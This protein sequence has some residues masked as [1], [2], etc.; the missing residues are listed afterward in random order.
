MSD[1]VH[2]HRWQ[3]T[4]LP[5]PWDSLGK[6]AGVGCHFLL[7]LTDQL[8]DFLTATHHLRPPYLASSEKGLCTYLE[9]TRPQGLHTQ[10]V[11]CSVM[12]KHIPKTASSPYLC[13]AGLPGI[14]PASCESQGW[15]RCGARVGTLEASLITG[16]LPWQTGRSEKLV[17]E[18]PAAVHANSWS[19]PRPGSSVPL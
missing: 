8:M 19:V 3:P 9:H 5:H 13:S 10:P 11:L 17:S 16:R 4:R 7:W 6:N 14:E 15:D 2:P 1:S 12:L 18:S